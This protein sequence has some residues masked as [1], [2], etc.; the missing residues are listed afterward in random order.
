MAKKV[1]RK[2]LPP[3]KRADVHTIRASAE[4]WVA[5][6]QAA[7]Q[8]GQPMHTWIREMLDQAAEHYNSL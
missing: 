2:R 6:G 3:N 4:Q 5:W 1:G 8:A 7:T